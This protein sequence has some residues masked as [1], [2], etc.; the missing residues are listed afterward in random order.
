M[1]NAKYHV[2]L[3]GRKLGPYDRRTIVGM[4]IKKTLTTDDVLIAADGGHL[5]VGE[6][7][8]LRRPTPFHA[9][10]TGSFSVVQARF[11]ASLVSMQGKG[12][13]IPRFKG[14]MEVRVQKDVLRL[15]GRFRQGLDWKED[16]VKLPLKAFAH[17]RQRESQLDMWL[18]GD[19]PQGLQKITLELF[20]QE[21]ALSL[22]NALPDATAW[23]GTDQEAAG[24]SRWRATLAGGRAAWAGLIVA[25]G[26]VALAAA[27]FLRR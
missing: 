22:L 20:T 14:E 13:A 27:L 11:P 26:L 4:R 25:G 9:E 19:A 5:T 15:A 3:E 2:V 18:T 10:R 24:L 16:R 7:I 6:L 1:D 8:K 21:A 12:V 17:A 23:P